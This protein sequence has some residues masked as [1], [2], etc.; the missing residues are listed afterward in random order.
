MTY[1]VDGKQ[2][3]GVAAGNTVMVFGLH[4]RSDSISSEVRSASLVMND[5]RRRP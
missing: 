2:Y 5:A 4:Y 1:T 3:I